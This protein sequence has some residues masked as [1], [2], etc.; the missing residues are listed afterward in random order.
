MSI[1][2]EYILV[3]F[4]LVIILALVPY[5]SRTKMGRRIKDGN[6]IK[7]NEKVYLDNTTKLYVVDYEGRKLFVASN[8]SSISITVD[9][10]HQDNKNEH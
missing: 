8:S 9:N 2:I 6:K 3:L 10:A 4:L 7:V 5:I 1:G